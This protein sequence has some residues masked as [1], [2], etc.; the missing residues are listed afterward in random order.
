MGSVTRFG[1]FVV[2]LPWSEKRKSDYMYATLMEKEEGRRESGTLF[3]C[4][5]YR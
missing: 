3:V 5:M 1:R 2:C 4:T